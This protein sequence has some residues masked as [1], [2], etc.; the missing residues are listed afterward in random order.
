MPII[1]I[2]TFAPNPPFF[3]LLCG[4]WAEL[5]KIFFCLTAQCSAVSVEG[6]GGTSPSF[7]AFSLA[8]RAQWLASGFL[9][10]FARI[11]VGGS[12]VNSKGSPLGSV[13]ASPVVRSVG[14]FHANLFGTPVSGLA[15]LARLRLRAL[16]KLALWWAL[17]ML[18]KEVWTS[19][20][21]EFVSSL[22]TLLQPCW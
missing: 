3:A 20:F 13:L 9:S 2:L 1:N 21:S 5:Y 16:S 4:T 18:S 22:G 8:P 19:S 6:T 11:P 17:A 15:F 7:C 10:S 12:R 14:S